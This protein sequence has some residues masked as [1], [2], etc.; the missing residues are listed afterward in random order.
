MAEYRVRVAAYG[1][2]NTAPLYG[3]AYG[4]KSLQRPQEAAICTS[5]EGSVGLAA[6]T[7]KPPGLLQRRAEQALG[8]LPFSIMS[9]T[10]PGHRPGGFIVTRAP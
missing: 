1:V 9:A 4:Q 3:V 6:P 2:L 8:F 7:I 5:L 10:V